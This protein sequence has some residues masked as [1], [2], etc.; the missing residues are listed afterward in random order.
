MRRLSERLIPEH[1]LKG[2]IVTYELKSEDKITAVSTEICHDG[3]IYAPICPKCR[4]VN[5]ARPAI[6]Q[7]WRCDTEGCT[8]GVIDWP[9]Y[10]EMFPHEKEATP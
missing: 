3:W 6:G 2:D 5:L 1:H 10:F 4:T 8:Q 7:P 9:E